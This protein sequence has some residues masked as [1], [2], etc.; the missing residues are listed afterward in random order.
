[1]LFLGCF[2]ALWLVTALE[3]FDSETISEVAWAESSFKQSFETAKTALLVSTIS[4][5]IGYLC[6]RVSL[7]SRQSAVWLLLYTLCFALTPYLVAQGWIQLWPV[8]TNT[9]FAIYSKTGLVFLQVLQFA[10]L[11]FLLFHF[12]HTPPSRSQIDL[13]RLLELSWIRM[14]W[15]I[16]LPAAAASCTLCLVLV[17]WLSFWNYETPSILREKTYALNLYA[18]FGSFYDYEQAL[19]YIL[20]ATMYVLP[21]LL[22]LGV[23]IKKKGEL[24]RCFSAETER[25]FPATTILLAILPVLALLIPLYGILQHIPS[26]TFLFEKWQEYSSDIT[27][28]LTVGLLAALISSGTALS[29]QTLA[30]KLQATRY[31]IP[32]AFLLFFIPSLGSGIGFLHWFTES[33]SGEAGIERLVLVNAVLTLPLALLAA[34]V[35]AP[36]K[37]HNEIDTLALYQTS[38]VSRIKLFA[39]HYTLPRYLLLLTLCFL[40][41]I[42]EVPASLLN[43][44]PDGSTLVLSIETMLHFEQPE[45]IS[46][47]CLAQ[48]LIAFG[49]TAIA[50]TAIHYLKK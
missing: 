27:N 22:G 25:T 18:A 17:F 6:F 44:P 4:S 20:H 13:E 8:T 31:L 40:F 7:K 3:S 38:L 14:E 26:T 45:L 35:I 37:A 39:R 34:A 21:C 9:N 29:L 47:L 15:N 41:T 1:M 11:T 32:S 16:R 33:F 28:T 50:L 5:L 12:T 36:Q 24:H 19:S 46:S 48:L 42:R 30:I 49:A 2:P 23:F 10:P 43:Y